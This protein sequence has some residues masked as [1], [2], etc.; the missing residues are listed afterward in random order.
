[1]ANNNNSMVLSDLTLDFADFV[2]QFET[3]LGN[4]NVWRGNLTTMT[5]QTL[6]ELVSTVGVLNQGRITRVYEDAFSETAQSDDAIR[7]ITQMQGLRMSRKLPAGLEVEIVA[8]ETITIPP[9]TQFMV[10]GQYYFNRQQIVLLSNVT[11]LVT[12][13]QGQ[14]V[15]YAMYGAGGP[16]QTYVSEE[17]SSTVSDQDVVV[18]VNGVAIPKSYGTLWNYKNLPAWADLTTSD[19]RL[20]AVFGSLQFGTTPIAT[21]RV[22]ISYPITQGADASNVALINK[23]V[24]ATGFSSL[25][26]T[27]KS[28]P[29]GGG[30]EQPINAYKNLASGSFGTYSSA[31]TKSQYLSTVGV[32]PGIID[33][34]TQAQ[35]D[36]NTMALE[37]MNVIRVSGLTTSP[38]T[39]QQKKDFITYLQTV[40][41]YAGRFVWQDAIPVYRNIALTVYVFNTA[42]P[43]KV[44]ADCEA[45]LRALFAPRPG[46]LL[47]NFY[48]SDLTDATKKA[49]KGMQSY[50]V[51]DH[52]VAPMI[53]TAPLSPDLRYDI[54]DT[55]GTLG[56]LVYAYGVSTINTAGEEGAPA[57][58]VF[59]QIFSVNNIHSI[60]LSW[61]ALPDTATYKV[62]GRN[63]TGIGLMATI[64]QGATPVGQT[65]TFTDNG[66]IVPDA[67]QQP[68]GT[69]NVPIRYN[70]LGTLTVRVEFAER[71]QRLTGTPTREQ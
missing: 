64:Q 45:E 67:S 9:M 48:E 22:T 41:M 32:Y 50:C 43:T 6:I 56:S 11:Q 62:W 70:A 25:T 34:V 36:I 57:N 21:D 10:G 19:G 51:V 29:T 15:V 26:G 54:L 24:T 7:S 39:Q 59:P 42:T 60:A 49:S 17:D 23:R 3:Y 8:P 55:G 27:A 58:W 20:L 31:V 35:R 52:P 71:Q 12:L 69:N 65:I 2:T 40:T 46:L 5:S 4:R 61:P 13:F 16:R 1:M 37:W 18:R 47:T 14:V 63:S 38:W 53:V 33:A 28:N 66:S 68:G 44:K 30:N